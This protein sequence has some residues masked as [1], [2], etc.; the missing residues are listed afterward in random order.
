MTHTHADTDSGSV[1]RVSKEKAELTIQSVA[2]WSGKRPR[3]SGWVC[4]PACSATFCCG[5]EAP[6]LSQAHSSLFKAL[7]AWASPPSSPP[8][9]PG[10]PS[11]ISDT[12]VS[13]CVPH[14]Q[15]RPARGEREL[16][17]PGRGGPGPVTSWSLFSFPAAVSGNVAGCIT[18]YPLRGP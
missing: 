8:Q 11:Q 5:R 2:G 14:G 3:H 18:F 16:G 7:P 15:S 10:I 12:V 17:H 1:G 9:P 6:S 13:R 4:G